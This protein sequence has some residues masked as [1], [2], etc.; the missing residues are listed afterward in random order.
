[1]KKPYNMRDINF[2]N[3]VFSK[4]IN[5]NS[6]RSVI[7]K[8]N[9][10]N[11]LTKILIQTPEMRI[12]DLYNTNNINIL[13]LAVDSSTNK[14]DEFIKFWSLLDNHII[15][16]ARNN[17]NWFFS[18][19]VK[20]KGSIRNDG[21]YNVPYIKLKINSDILNKIKVSYDKQTQ[22]RQFSDLEK[23]QTIKLVLD[24]Y[25]IW[26]NSIGFGLYT[27]P[28]VIDIR[29]NNELTFNESSEEDIID[30]EINSISE[31]SVLNLNTDMND[32]DDRMSSEMDSVTNLIELEIE[33][34]ITNK[35]R[36]SEN[37]E[38]ESSDDN[39]NRILLKDDISSSSSDS[40]NNDSF[41][42]NTSTDYD[43]NNH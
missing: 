33:D 17:N 1:M 18:N 3:I 6:K 26:I 19:N 5:N 14:V 16:I 39:K 28:V 10:N 22:P 25:G 32:V 30:T 41:N 24:V 9:K 8:Y 38:T 35:N 2:N 7:T 11:K 13:V 36:I 15:S 31:M 40:N 43:N 37:S 21:D 29:E 27:K 20:F 34:I 42:I 12:L 23:D 4:V